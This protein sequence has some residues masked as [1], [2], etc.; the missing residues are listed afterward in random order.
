MADFDIGVFA[1]QKP[2]L[3]HWNQQHPC[4]LSA[5]GGEGEFCEAKL[6]GAKIARDGD[7]WPRKG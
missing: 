1:Q 7:F 3:T 6:R 2:H 4:C 5:E